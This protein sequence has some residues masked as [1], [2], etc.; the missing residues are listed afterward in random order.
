MIFLFVFWVIV[1]NLLACWL[2]A[3]SRC[4]LLS[5]SLAAGV[6]RRP[7]RGRQTGVHTRSSASSPPWPCRPPR[8]HA[9]RYCGSA[10]RK[11][12]PLH[13]RLRAPPRLRRL[14]CARRLCLCLIASVSVL[15]LW[16]IVDGSTRNS[17]AGLASSPGNPAPPE[18]SRGATAAWERWQEAARR[19]RGGVVVGSGL[20]VVRVSCQQMGRAEGMGKLGRQSPIAAE[21]DP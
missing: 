6:H 13:A 4:A 15:L 11:R 17:A 18:A 5:P 16:S 12:R 21:V 1:S 3:R 8:P 10:G 19:N 20:R 9:S 7:R 2:V 14:S